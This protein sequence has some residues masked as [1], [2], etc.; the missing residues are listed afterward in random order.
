MFG[1]IGSSIGGAVGGAI[2]GVADAIL[3]LFKDPFSSIKSGINQ[4]QQI[5]NSVID[6]LRN[7]VPQVQSSWIGTDSDQFAQDVNNR[8]VPFGRGLFDLL[9]DLV[10]RLNRAEEIMNQADEKVKSLYS[11]LGDVF[12]K[13]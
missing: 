3:S 1:S 5:V 10:Q 13:I 12:S 4:Q 2:G 6:G 11:G 7:L 9:K 8:I